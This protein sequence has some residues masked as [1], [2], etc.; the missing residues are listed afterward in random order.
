MLPDLKGERRTEIDLKKER[1]TR[2]IE[3]KFG[4][5]PEAA[6]KLLEFMRG[7][8]GRIIEGEE[9]QMEIPVL[10]E[11]RR[12]L[13]RFGQNGLQVEFFALND[14]DKLVYRGP[15]IKIKEIILLPTEKGNC[16]LFVTPDDDWY[17][18][19]KQGEFFWMPG[20]KH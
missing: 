3:E 20:S 10:A 12:T 15:Q 13:L 4:G 7:N 6:S 5:S 9:V 16:P 8:G 11:R 19:G 17:L 18:L 14:L 1:F 2:V